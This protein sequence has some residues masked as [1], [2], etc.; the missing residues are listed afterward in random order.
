MGFVTNSCCGGKDEELFTSKE[1]SVNLTRK[2]ALDGSRQ[3]LVAAFADYG[4]P[5]RIPDPIAIDPIDE[6][7]V[8]HK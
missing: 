2:H 3:R 8:V 6:Q 1:G 5:V 7:N 4:A